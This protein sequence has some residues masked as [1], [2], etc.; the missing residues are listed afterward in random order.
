MQVLV[1]VAAVTAALGISYF[2][3][4]FSVKG[5]E[6]NHR[7]EKERVFFGDTVNYIQ[8]LTNV[9]ILPLPWIRVDTEVPAAIEFLK[10]NLA[11]HHRADKKI[12]SGL[13][14]LLW[15]QKVR[16]KYPVYCRNRGIFALGPGILS[17]G[18]VFGFFNKEKSLGSTA[19]LIVY[20]R[21]VDVA[22]VEGRPD[23]TL[24]GVSGRK[25]LLT[26]P[27]YFTGT[28]D[29][30]PGDPPKD[31]EW[32]ST[33]KLE[34]LRVKVY[35]SS[36]TKKICILL[37]VN[38]FEI[39]WEGIDPELSEF[40]VMLAAS[41][42]KRALDQGCQVMLASNGRMIS[43][44]KDTD[45]ITLI[46][47]GSGSMHLRTILECLARLSNYSIFKMEEMMPGTLGMLK[48]G[49]KVIYITGSWGKN[50]EKVV[51]LLQKMGMDV[52]LVLAG[53]KNAEL[54]GPEGVLT[55]HAFGEEVWREISLIRLV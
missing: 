49:S 7:F 11:P 14:S 8:E 6:F 34:R 50:G 47:Y 39:A 32:K 33:A 26:D 38:T 52:A 18:D 24:S 22:V 4:A 25:T 15:Y 44:D 45:L 30:V 5:L 35:D 23:I 17:T 46:P 53:R 42:S 19:R 3:S 2:W 36:F 55:Y 40:L 54:K 12:L 29:Y 1:L 27:F 37:D 9:K 43:P 51:K 20:P 41:I 28:R 21:I 10:G 31:V 16:R 48:K 13:Y